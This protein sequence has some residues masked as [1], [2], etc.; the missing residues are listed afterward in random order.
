MSEMR[1][2]VIRE[3]CVRAASLSDTR[4]IQTSEVIESRVT[5]AFRDDLVHFRGERDFA[6]RAD[7]AAVGNLTR[8]W[9]DPGRMDR[10]DDLASLVLAK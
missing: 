7:S 4:S 10:I 3:K 2:E 8:N 6:E 5:V 1:V 9:T